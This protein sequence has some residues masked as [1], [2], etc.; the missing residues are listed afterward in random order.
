METC[1]DFKYIDFRKI[2]INFPQLL[3]VD[4]SIVI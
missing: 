1:Q 4:S 3:I 2:S